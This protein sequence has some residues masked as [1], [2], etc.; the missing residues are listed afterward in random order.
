VTIGADTNVV[1]RYLV[2]DDRLQYEK[3]LHLIERHAALGNPVIISLLV[4]M[5]SEWVLRSRYQLSKGEILNAF[6]SML[7]TADL[8]FEDEPSVERALNS[9]KDSAADFADCLI[10]A[11]NRKLGC[12]ATATFDAKALKLP[13]F[14]AVS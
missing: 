2:R 1:I 12:R 7:E 13:G 3:S 9:W 6:S 8:V 11:H 4:L 14:I 5:E 10:E